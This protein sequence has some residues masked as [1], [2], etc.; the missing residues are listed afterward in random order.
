MSK[1]FSERIRATRIE[2][3]I[4]QSKLAQSIKVSTRTYQEYEYNKCEPSIDKSVKI[5]DELNVSL[6][7]LTGRTDDNSPFRTENKE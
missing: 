1:I 2:K 3:K 5:A 6:D 4:T 7:Y